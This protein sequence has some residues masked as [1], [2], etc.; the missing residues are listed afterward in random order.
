MEKDNVIDEN[1]N[2]VLDCMDAPEKL[3]E[4]MLCRFS[5]EE[6]L[7]D[8]FR[9]LQACKTAVRKEYTRHAPDIDQEWQRFQNKHTPRLS[10]KAYLWRGIG[11]GVA[12]TLLVLLGFSLMKRYYFD[13]SESVK[14]FAA[15][16][17]VQEVMLQTAGGRQLALN[18]STQ[19][20]SLDGMGLS[21]EQSAEEKGL[22]YASAPEA[23]EIE[24]HLL[25]T[26]R[27][28]DFKVTLADGS[29]VW[30]NAESQLE[31]PSRFV[32]KE[33]KVR[34]IGEAYFQIASNREMPFIVE[35]NNMSTRV[36]GTEFNLCNY[37]ER[38]A[39]VT[40]IK[41]SVEVKSPKSK[42]GYVRMA[43]G[44]DAQLQPDGSFVLKEVDID[45]YVYWKEGFFYFDNTPLVDIMQSI[46]R[47]YNINVVFQNPEAMKYRMHY[48]CDRK[49]GIEHVVELFNLMRKVKVELKDN[50]VYVQ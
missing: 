7:R 3:T 17:L 19:T 45:S 35:T 30:L 27:G 2:K 34:L 21:L 18:A 15:N 20:E 6:D 29:I 41:G 1:I 24:T 37:S 47:W 22:I 13:T 32:G 14:V 5:E 40:L 26:P 38:D 33:R 28:Q 31:Y 49:G 25:S 9:D 39:H 42:G 16:N 23:V 8:A 11:M 12:A 46:G 4:D 10:K 44:E 36:L 43:P 48:L 50:T